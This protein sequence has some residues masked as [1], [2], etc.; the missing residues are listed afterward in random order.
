MTRSKL[1]RW[2]KKLSPTAQADTP[3]ASRS[4]SVTPDIERSVSPSHPA[5]TVSRKRKKQPSQT[6]KQRSSSKRSSRKKASQ[7]WQVSDFVVPEMEGKLR[8]HDLELPEPLLHAIH[9]LGFE[10]CSPIQA[11]SLPHGLQGTDIIG[12]AQTG[13][14]KTAAFLIT[15][16]D[17]FIHDPIEESRVKFQPR[18]LI[19]A[20]TRELVTQIADDA[21][22]LTR[23]S[24]LKTVTLIGGEPY[25]KQYRELQSRPVDIVVATPGRLIDF[26]TRQD[27]NLNYV[28]I[29]V[30]DEADRMLDMGF[31]PQ[32]KRIVRATPDK[33]ARQ[34]LLYSATFPH[35]IINLSEQWSY[36]P[37]HLEIEAE[38]VAAESIDQKVYLVAANQKFRLLLNL[39]KEPET[40]LALIFAN[41]RDQTQRLY[42]E[43][44]KAGV[45]VGILSGEISQQRRT[46]T[47]ER[48]KS[49]HFKALVATDVM[50]RGIHVD[51]ISHVI[52]FNLPDNPEDYVH[53]IGRTGRAESEGVSISFACENE[54]FQLPIIEEYM[55]QALHCEA[56]PE[57]LL[58][59]S[60]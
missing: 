56:P 58:R 37:I 20:P 29:L 38:Q 32:I 22:D 49:G 25:D 55:G 12:K 41:R 48:F 44:S 46:R 28:E 8:F 51:G 26:L 45:R 52:N 33:K 2:F 11:K 9:D 24:N 19:L 7:P 17:A 54:S 42:R 14:G 13:T 6:T 27:I 57:H 34:T 59:R 16:I 18:A 3:P 60:S 5:S 47:L 30:I 53:R 31:I 36:K 39:L 1:R 35:D 21:L 10:Y 4:D 40:K 50:G 15:I 23:Y 43:L